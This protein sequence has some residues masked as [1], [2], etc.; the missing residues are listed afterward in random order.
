MSG[1]GAMCVDAKLRSP[2]ATSAAE[3]DRRQKAKSDAANDA[4]TSEGEGDPDMFAAAGV[5]AE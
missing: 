1:I 4:V 5:A 2:Q 3:H